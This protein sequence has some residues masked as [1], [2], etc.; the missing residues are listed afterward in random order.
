MTGFIRPQTSYRAIFTEPDVHV[1]EANDLPS[2]S[3]G[4]I[5]L[6]NK[7]YRIPGFVNI[8]TNNIDISNSP[9]FKGEHDV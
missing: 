8:G 1:F 2:P 6:E 4:T 3:G 5:T 9:V 7:V